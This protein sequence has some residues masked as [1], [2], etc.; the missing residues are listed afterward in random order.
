MDVSSWS[1]R[2][3]KNSHSRWTLQYGKDRNPTCQDGIVQQTGELAKICPIP[4]K[5]EGSSSEHGCKIMFSPRQHEFT[6]PCTSG[7]GQVFPDS[8]YSCRNE[9]WAGQRRGRSVHVDVDVHGNVNL[10]RRGV[11]MILHPCS[12]K[13][14]PDFSGMGQIFADSPHSCRN[15]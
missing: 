6:S 15:K 11:N 7:M 13:L 4:E 2:V 8:P 5:S 12:I 9:W 10:C 14:A 1:L 3:N